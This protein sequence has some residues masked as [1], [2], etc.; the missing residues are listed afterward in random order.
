MEDGEF[1][2]EE[3][4]QQLTLPNQTGIS[5]DNRKIM[6]WKMDIPNEG[7]KATSI[8]FRSCIFPPGYKAIP[9]SIQKM[10]LFH[11]KL[12]HKRSMGRVETECFFSCNFLCV[13][14]SGR[15]SLC[16]LCVLSFTLVSGLPGLPRGGGQS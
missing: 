13:L 7:R 4:C 6:W 12:T 14:V 15:K 9:L 11:Q 3:P 10:L 16:Q 1:S 2:T 8:I 5:V